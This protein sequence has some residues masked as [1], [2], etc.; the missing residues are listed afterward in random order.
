MMESPKQVKGKDLLK[1]VRKPFLKQGH[2]IYA[3]I[4]L[5]KTEPSPR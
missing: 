4:I 2:N 5:N 3:K 1:T